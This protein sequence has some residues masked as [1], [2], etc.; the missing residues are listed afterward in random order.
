MGPQ[1][2]PDPPK[3]GTGDRPF[4]SLRVSGG[5]RVPSALREPQG[6]RGR[7]ELG[8]GQRGRGEL[9]RGQQGRGKQGR[10][11][12]GRGKQRPYGCLASR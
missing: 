3:E 6:E 10:G 8:R 1:E 7:G 5:C 9:G 4:E 12:Q 11:E 2:E